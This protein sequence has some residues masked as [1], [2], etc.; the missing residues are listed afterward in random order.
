MPK[1]DTE[2][3]KRLSDLKI[4]A[5]FGKK[6]REATTV[7]SHYSAIREANFFAQTNHLTRMRIEI[8]DVAKAIALSGN[9][10]Q[11][12]KTKKLVKKIIPDG[13]R[14]KYRHLL[15]EYKLKK[16]HRIMAEGLIDEKFS[17]AGVYRDHPI[18]T[19]MET[20]YPAPSEI[21]NAMK[22]Y[23]RDFNKYERANWNPIAFS[24]WASTQ[25]VK[26]H[27]FSDFNGRMSRLIMNMIF[28]S[29]QLPFYVSLKSNKK[30]RKRYFTALRQYSRR[31]QS[32]TTLISMQLIEYFENLNEVLSIS[33]M[34]E[35]NPHEIADPPP[36]ISDEELVKT[37][38][39]SHLEWI[40]LAR[41][42][43]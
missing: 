17:P 4:I 42:D 2:K 16:L 15:T 6:T 36:D 28:R 8:F 13:K 37:S 31:K 27:P 30:D 39:A 43:K 22:I 9:T 10:E 40:M 35:I 41:Q 34:K 25:F 23:I 19:D 29:N 33:G 38:Q 21:K 5:K 24:A 18:M 32:I 11:K 26:I 12:K 7:S 20:H 3:Q 14:P 1:L